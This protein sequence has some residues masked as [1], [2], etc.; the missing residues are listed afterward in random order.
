MSWNRWRIDLSWSFCF[1]WQV[2][3][4]QLS[5]GVQ[6]DK[7]KNGFPGGKS[8]QNH[9]GKRVLAGKS[10]QMFA[11]RRLNKHNFCL[12]SASWIRCCIGIKEGMAVTWNL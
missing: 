10:L 3:H 7:Q 5:P 2:W 9:V 1:A 8:D 11:V 6:K 4:G 12:A